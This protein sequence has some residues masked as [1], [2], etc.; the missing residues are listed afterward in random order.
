MKKSIIIVALLA[1]GTAAMAQDEV[2][3]K[4]GKATMSEAYYNELVAKAR[5]LDDL[6]KENQ[7]IAEKLQKTEDKLQRSDKVRLSSF[8][9]SASYAIGQDIYNSWQNNMLG[10]NGI[11]A[12][13]GMRDAVNNRFMLNADQVQSL[14]R[15]FQNGF[16]QRQSQQIDGNIA[17]GKEFM[18]KNANNKSVYTT[19]S[20]LQYQRLKAGNGKKPKVGDNVVV[21][22]TGT[23]IDGKKFDSSLDRNEPFRFEVGRGV[24]IPGWDEGLQLMEVGSK[25]RLVIPYNL[26]YG[27]RPVGSI[28]AGST[29]IFEIEL[30]EIVK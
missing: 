6:Q 9:D 12:A 18:A 7:S 20:G 1:L 28:P 25:Y 16:E 22:Y 13:A 30:L 17:A 8:N 21:H 2:K 3:I 24:V 15:R 27:D 14:L 11:A 26:A 23:L 19:S 4:K 5:Q 29:L 10:I